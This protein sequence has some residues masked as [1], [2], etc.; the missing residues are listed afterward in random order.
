MRGVC[1]CFV[2]QCAFVPTRTVLA[3]CFS[4][5]LLISIVCS[6]VFLGLIGWIIDRGCRPVCFFSWRAY[7]NRSR[8]Y[9]PSDR[10]APRDSR[11]WCVLALSYYVFV[12]RRFCLFC[13]PWCAPHRSCLGLLVWRIPFS[14]LS[15]RSDKL[16]GRRCITGCCF[17]P[18]LALLRRDFCF[19]LD[20]LLCFISVVG[21]LLPVLLPVFSRFFCVFLNICR[22]LLRLMW[23]VCFCNKC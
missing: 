4:A 11:R 16:S 17:Y 12:C 6:A 14:I 5:R 20:W 2:A 13:C 15:C 18:L 8:A 9:L 21:A 23:V 3:K 22:F 7:S 19:F 1:L 10:T